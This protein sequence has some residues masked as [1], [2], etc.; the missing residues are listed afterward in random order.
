MRYWYFLLVLVFSML[1]IPYSFAQSLNEYLQMGGES[2]PD[3][4]AR[5]QSYLSA[6][7]QLPQQGALPDPKLSFSYFISPVE[8]RLGPQQARISLQQM[9]PWFGS[10]T[11]REDV[12]SQ[13][14]KVRFEEFV[15][16]RN[17]Y[18][19]ELKKNYFQLYELQQKRTLLQANIDILQVYEEVA[20]QKYE[21]DLSSMVDIIRVQ[22]QLREEKS[23]LQN[24]LEETKAQRSNFNT[25]LNRATEAEVSLPD[26]LEIGEVAADT[27][28][29]R[30]EML[31]NYPS[32][33]LLQEEAI[34]L[35]KSEK[36]AQLS[37]KPELGL[38]LD[39]VLIGERT[40]MEMADSGKDALMLMVNVSLPL[41]NQQKYKSAVREIRIES[42]ANQLAIRNEENRIRDELQQALSQLQSAKN[43]ILLYHKQ[44]ESTQQAISILNSAY[45]ANSKG[46]EE[47]LEFQLELLKYQNLLNESTTRL[48]IALA[49]ID[50]LRAIE[51]IDTNELK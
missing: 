10:L 35:E 8:T 1:S 5:Y 49:K 31:K 4:Q 25:L 3:L 19:Y 11:A 42:E 36:V 24:L 27:S 39:Y 20:T 17:A 21:N 29:I 45:E 15:Q 7:Q 51:I 28:Q 30:A 12:A 23:K 16:A 33:R 48:Y 37:A 6:L 34:L 32:I 38:G 40:D 13:R 26:T 50:E 43:D 47:V 2:N 9:L 22:M 14:A 46:F 18:F 41:F 44:I